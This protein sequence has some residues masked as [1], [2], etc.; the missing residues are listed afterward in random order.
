MLGSDASPSFPW[1]AWIGS[2][3]LGSGIAWMALRAWRGRALLP[4][5]SNNWP[6]Q[7][8]WMIAGLFPAAGVFLFAAIALAAREGTQTDRIVLIKVLAW[9]LFCIA[10]ALT[11]TCIALLFALLFRPSLADSRLRFLV[12]PNLRTDQ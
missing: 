5:A 11:V 3:A 2:I 1:A 9:P 10:V 6:K 12:P 4:G 7:L 8:G